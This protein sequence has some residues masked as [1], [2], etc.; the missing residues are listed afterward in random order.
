MTAYQPAAEIL[1]VLTD[2]ALTAE[3]YY[4]ND[5]AAL[6]LTIPAE[7]RQPCEAEVHRRSTRTTYVK[8]STGK[9]RPMDEPIADAHEVR[10]QVVAEI[11]AQL[12]RRQP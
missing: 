5:I 7:Y 9:D 2:E 6:L 12:A 10:T 8:S 4:K 11:R 3:A 1:P